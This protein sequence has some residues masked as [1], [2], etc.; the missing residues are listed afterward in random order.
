MD[1]IDYLLFGR[2]V[3]ELQRQLDHIKQA[4]SVSNPYDATE[5]DIERLQ[6]E[7]AGVQLYVNALIQ[8]LV[9]K[10]IASQE[11]IDRAVQA[12][13]R[14]SQDAEGPTTPEDAAAQNVYREL[15]LCGDN[16]P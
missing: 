5:Q 12:M 1:T 14:P 9:A 10:G 4:R 13:L 3:K 7:V 8:I 16:A 11:E 2:K 6:A 15:G